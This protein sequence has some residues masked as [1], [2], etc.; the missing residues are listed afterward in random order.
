MAKKK[1]STK[2]LDVTS[3]YKT[4]FTSEAGKRVLWDIMRNSFVLASTY[5]E[6]SNEMAL[7]EGQRNVALRILSVLQTDEQKLLQQ[8]EEGLGYDGEYGDDWG[9]DYV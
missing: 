9:R 5:C 7:R 8:I 1:V 2:K 3:D 6:N 4:V